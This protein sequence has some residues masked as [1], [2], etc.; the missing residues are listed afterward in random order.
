M[1][2]DATGDHVAIIGENRKLLVFPLAQIAQMGRGRGVRLQRYRDGNVSDIRVFKGEDGLTWT[3]SSGAASPARWRSFP[4]GSATAA[5]QAACPRPGSRAR[6]SWAEDALNQ[7]G[8]IQ[9]PPFS[10]RHAKRTFEMTG[11]MAL[12][13]KATGRGRCRK[14]FATRKAA[15]DPL[16]TAHDQIPMRAR[17]KSRPELSGQR[18]P[19]QT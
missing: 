12:V 9:L 4:N 17:S 2:V 6:T 18:K 15:L 14:A 19:V 3:D 10:R 16:Q 5:R 13:C 8:G 7:A 1:C 11:H